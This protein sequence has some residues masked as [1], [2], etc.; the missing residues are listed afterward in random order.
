MQQKETAEVGH[1]GCVHSALGSSSNP[2]MPSLEGLPPPWA[3]GALSSQVTSKCHIS[4]PVL[5]PKARGP[6]PRVPRWQPLGFVLG[7]HFG[8]FLPFPHPMPS[9]D[10]YHT[11]R[12]LGGKVNK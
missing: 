3:A 7:Y 5:R 1:G 2:E 10:S 4:S 9:T 6:S 8:V 12:P 11:V